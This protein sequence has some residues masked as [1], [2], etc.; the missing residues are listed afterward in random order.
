MVAVATRPT[1][2]PPAQGEAYAA[3][4]VRAHKSLMQA[5]PDPME[6]NQVVW[7][8]WS[9]V[10]GDHDRER[11]DVFFRPD[12][13]EKRPNVC[14]FAEHEATSK[15][16]QGQPVIRR[17]DAA[18]LGEIVEENNLRI[19]DV[20][21]YPTIIDRHTAGPGMRDPSPP[22]TLGAAGPLR[23]GMVGRVQPRF[24]IYADEYVKHSC[25]DDIQARPGRS[26]EVLTLKANGRTYI[27]PIAAISEAPRLPLPVQFSFGHDD[28]EV[29]ER[30]QVQAPYSVA[31]AFPGG[32]N[33]FTQKFDADGD[34][35]A[36]NQPQESGS[37]LTDDDIRRMLDAFSNTD[38]MKWVSQQMQLQGTP[39]GGADPQP[40]PMPAGQPGG[41]P[42][43]AA[44]Q[45][46][47]QFMGG[48]GSSSMGMMNGRYATTEDVEALQEQYS[49]LVDSQRE[50]IN[51]LA[52]ANARLEVMA[53]ERSDAVRTSRI[54]ELAGR[55]SAVDVD[56]EMERCLYAH[57]SDMSDK[58]FDDHIN[59]V[60]RYAAKAIENAPMLPGGDDRLPGNDRESAQ[61]SA[62]VSAE[63]VRLNNEFVNQGVTK[64]YHELKT[65]ARENL[66]S[67]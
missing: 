34:D 10:H 7:A 65:M 25:K 58:Q 18:K 39:A 15:D 26:V 37:M 17:Y 66:A 52:E 23:L 56:Q 13:F 4:V 49:A 8:A 3:Y 29:V 46:R 2:P 22:R 35:P 30:Y 67:R 42:Q 40:E 57:G 6:R 31:A 19:A 36:A 5:V 54:H 21:A 43:P 16:A 45:Q 12:Q 61:Y 44:P 48:M 11:A 1:A 24:A 9:A 55:Y 59:M 64:S 33:T 27:N 51:D 63:I 14:Y 41:V 47:D 62:Q 32:G 38:Q 60:E 20:D 53:T 50:L 28:D